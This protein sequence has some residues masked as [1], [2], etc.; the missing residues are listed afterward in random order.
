MHTGIKRNSTNFYSDFQIWTCSV[1]VTLFNIV[2]LW[3]NPFPDEV[4]G[5][6]SSPQSSNAIAVFSSDHC[7]VCATFLRRT[8]NYWNMSSWVIKIN[9]DVL[10]SSLSLTQS[11]LKWEFVSLIIWTNWCI[12]EMPSSE[13]FMVSI[14]TFI[15]TSESLRVF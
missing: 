3:G 2:T 4:A 15:S 5:P 11:R 12:N 8:I 1:S 7:S 6:E 14:F 10:L 9:M 13:V